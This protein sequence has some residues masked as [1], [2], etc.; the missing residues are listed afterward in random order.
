M[1]VNL[2][3]WIDSSN[4]I[5][6]PRDRDGFAEN[7]II[8]ERKKLYPT[9][10]KE[11]VLEAASQLPGHSAADSA[12]EKIIREKNVESVLSQAINIEVSKIEPSSVDAA[13]PKYEQSSIGSEYSEDGILDI[14]QKIEGEEATVLMMMP[15]KKAVITRIKTREKITIEDECI[16]GKSTVGTNY[17]LIGNEMISRRHARIFRVGDDFY[18]E[19]LHSSNGTFIQEHR[20]NSPYKLEDGQQFM[21]ADEAFQV[22]IQ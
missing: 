9:F 13:L 6:P 5:I 12:A 20:I 1:S 7:V 17:R 19:D 16:L 3:R 10:S 21:F 4:A 18:I 2:N 11:S 22:D 15:P 8:R 14:D